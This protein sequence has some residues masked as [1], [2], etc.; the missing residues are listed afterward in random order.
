LSGK[1]VIGRTQRPKQTKVNFYGFLASYILFSFNGAKA[2][3]L[4][5][6][7]SGLRKNGKTKR[8]G[9]QD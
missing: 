9:F 6:L 4:P 7:P 5:L 2:P 3:F 1:Y 8:D